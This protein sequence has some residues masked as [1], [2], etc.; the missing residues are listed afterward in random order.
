VFILIGALSSIGG[1]GGTTALPSPD[2]AT[3]PPVATEDAT[4]SATTPGITRITLPELGGNMLAAGNFLWDATD[5]GAVRVDLTTRVVSEPIEGITNLA[6]DGTRLWA[7]GER[8][9]LE[10][11]PGTGEIIDRHAPE[12]SAYYLAATPEA[13]WASDTMASVLHRIDPTNGE[14]VAT[15]EVPT[16]PQGTTFGEGSVW[17][18]CDGAGVV[19]RVDPATN[20][21]VEIPVGNGPHSIAIADGW[22]WVINRFDSTLSKIDTKTNQV[23]ATVSD[24]GTSPAVGVEAGSGR[25]FAAYSGGIAVI[26]PKA[27]AITDRIAIPHTGFYDLKLVGNTLWASDTDHPALY[28]IDLDVWP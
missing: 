24:V 19:V 5:A 6:F 18:A 17:I 16:K 12:H 7:G 20:E 13:V 14:V 4:A 21:L 15:I 11:D 25:V 10:L 27:A 28:A 26:D 8:L 23:V 9:L 22:A 3:A 1:C 2:F